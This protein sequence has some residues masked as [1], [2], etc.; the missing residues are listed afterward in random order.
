[1]ACKFATERT[2]Q[3]CKEINTVANLRRKN[4]L[5]KFARKRFVAKFARKRF[6]ANFRGNR[7]CH[8]YLRRN[9]FRRKVATV[10][11]FLQI[12]EET[13]SVA[14]FREYC[15][16][17]LFATSRLRGNVVAQISR[18]ERFATEL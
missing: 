6:V 7:F 10:I 3:M 15:E 11:V 18:K 8:K 5:A 12:C 9:H 13:C 1:M 14:N 2:S 16:R 4:I 17:F